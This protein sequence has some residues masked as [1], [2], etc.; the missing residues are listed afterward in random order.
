MYLLRFLC[1]VSLLGITSCVD[2]DV[3]SRNYATLEDAQEDITKGWIPPTLPK[4]TY[5]ISDSHNLDLNTGEGTF[6]FEAELYWVYMNGL[7]HNLPENARGI[8]S[9]AQLSLLEDQGY[10]AKNYII[11]DTIYIVALHP[12]GKGRYWMAMQ[13]N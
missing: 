1:L 12:E 6:R 9:P 3:V 13:Y 10:H 11:E 8:P 7:S 5:D 4:T 2:L